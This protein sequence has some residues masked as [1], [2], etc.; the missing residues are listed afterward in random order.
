MNATLT[1][2]AEPNRL[3]IVELLRDKP[4]PVGE[5]NRLP[6]GDDGLEPLEARI[7]VIWMK[8]LRPAQ[9]HR[10]IAGPAREPSPRLV[11]LKAVPAVRR[12]PDHDRERRERRGR[13]D[14]VAN[15]REH[16]SG[17][18]PAVRRRGRIDAGS[19]GMIERSVSAQG[20]PL[21][22][23]QLRRHYARQ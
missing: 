9:P 6:S 4:R 22:L 2:L 19:G 5:E 18:T 7:T 17:P 13:R 8:D 12:P 10:F 14:V 3:R 16:G 15:G 21:V 11:H 20:G 23:I 1:A